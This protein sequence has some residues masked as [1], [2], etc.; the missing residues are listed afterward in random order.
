MNIISIE[1][2]ANIQK[3]CNRAMRSTLIALNNEGV[4]TAN[5][6]NKFLDDH[7]AV[8]MTDN[9][10]WVDWLKRKFGKEAQNVVV[11]CKTYTHAD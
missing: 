4:M 5:E 1:G 11:V 7:V 6:V 9:G 2:D 3:L 8:F 10:C